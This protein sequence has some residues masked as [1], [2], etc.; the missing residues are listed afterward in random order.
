MT[1]ATGVSRLHTPVL[2]IGAG[3]A[4]CATALVLA[5]AGVE[6]TLISSSSGPESGNSWLAQ[7]GII[8]KDLD[9]DPRLLEKDI[10]TAGHRHNS[11]KAVRHLAT[12]GPDA[13]KKILLERLGIPFSAPGA[14]GGAGG[15]AIPNEDGELDLTREGG[16]SVPRILHCADHTGR[17]IMQGLMA[18]VL[19]SPNIRLLSSCSAIDL[20]TSHHHTQGMTY[21]YQLENR[22]CGAYVLHEADNSVETILADYTV[23]ATGGAGQIY[24][25]S[26]NAGPVVGAAF[27]M[28]SRAGVR[29]E[30]LE[31]VQFHPTAF[32]HRD[33][34]RFLVTE[35]M[36]GEGAFLLDS[37]GRRFMKD[38][39]QRG[40]LAPRDVVSRAIVQEL[41]QS[42]DACVFLDARNVKH[43]LVRRFPTIYDHC[44]RY[45]VDITR[46]LIPVVPAAHYFCGGI[47]TDLAGRSSLDS[48][49]AVGECACTGLHGANRLASTSL[50]EALL[51]GNDAATD[52]MKRLGSRGGRMNAR[53]PRSIEDWH[54]LGDEHNDDPAL[55]AQDWASIRSI[56]WNYVGI[57]RTQSRLYRAFDDLRDLSRHLHD[58]Y[59]LTPLS[60]PLLD[61]FHGCQA[62]YILTQAALRNRKSLGC[63]QRLD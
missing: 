21:R 22:C 6:V 25:H 40:E 51:W 26:T 38:H 3:L 39:D 62:A 42:G 24:L 50:L 1:K 8:Y 17:S 45:G 54:H 47:L 30:N 43:D 29:L 20:L 16:H 12:R 13:V 27:S 33:S 34:R 10:L 4:G 14:H 15:H 18:A 57:T 63:H 58:F 56:M 2:V 28:A 36:R 32:Y 44:L 19:A 9:G 55:I 59:K 5:D 46:D 41:L 48:L 35:A 23:L 60:K 37:K 61:L 7:G 49:Y 52:I 31:Y 53:L 11:L